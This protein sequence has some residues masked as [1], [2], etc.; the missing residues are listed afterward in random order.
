MNSEMTKPSAAPTMT[1]LT[2]FSSTRM[3]RSL[4]LMGHRRGMH[5]TR[6]GQ[7]VT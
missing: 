6:P 7:V 2:T 1:R 5:N 3:R 4:P